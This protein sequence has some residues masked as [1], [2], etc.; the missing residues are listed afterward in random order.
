MSVERPRTARSRSEIVVEKRLAIASVAVDQLP[1]FGGD[2]RELGAEPRLRALRALHRVARPPDH[3]DRV[4][5]VA[6]GKHHMQ[7]YR[8]SDRWHLVCRDEE[9]AVIDHVVSG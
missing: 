9:A 4:E 1:R 8:L 7:A 6:A 2:L 5:F 3:G